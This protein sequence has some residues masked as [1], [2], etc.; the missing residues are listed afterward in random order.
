M[1]GVENFVFPS[2]TAQI[3]TPLIFH[4]APSP[5]LHQTTSVTPPGMRSTTLARRTLY[6]LRLL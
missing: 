2:S 1:E 5:P 6:S 3:K 4:S